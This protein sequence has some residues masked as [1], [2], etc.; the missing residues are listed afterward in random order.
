[1]QRSSDAGGLSVDLFERHTGAPPDPAALALQ[2]GRPVN[3]HKS[4]RRTSGSGAD[5]LY[6][7]IARK[8][9]D[10]LAGGSHEVGARL[11]AERDLA[12][13]HGVSRPVIREAMIALEVQGLIEVRVGAGAFVRRLPGPEDTPAFHVT[14]F[15]LT[16]ARLML[17][18]ES[19]AL[20][21]TQMTPAELDALDGLVKAIARE[22]EQP[23]YGDAADEAFHLL[24]ARATRNA[25]VV[26]TTKQ[27]WDLRSTS[28]ECALLHSRA[29]DADV[30]PV[31]DEHRAIA[32]AIRARDPATARAAMRAHLRNV[33]DSLLVATEELASTEQDPSLAKTRDRYARKNHEDPAVCHG[34]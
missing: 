12:E 18:G 4:V 17:E 24:I 34:R 7:R 28:P 11:A 32:V 27:Y 25:L 9:F 15:E 3:E 2:A 6:Q 1:V 20:A 30:R 14:G 21:A 16:E 26:K 13:L 23:T 33:I 31:V 22:N 10:E 8:L 29:R 5:R 19:A